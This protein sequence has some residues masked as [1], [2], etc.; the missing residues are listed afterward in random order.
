MKKRHYYYFL[1]PGT[2]FLLLFVVIPLLD[3]MF[4]TILFKN[5]ISFSGYAALFKDK[6]FLAIFFRSVKLSVISTVVCIIMG[7]PTSYFIAKITKNKAVYIALAIFP[8][9][10]SPVV[11]SFSWMVILGHNGFLNTLLLRCHLIKEPVQMLY[12]EF[13]IVV[14]LV[15]LFL[16]FMI[17]SVVGVMENINDD[18]ILAAENLGAPHFL[19]FLKVV[20]PLSVPGII[21]GSVL[22]LT[23]SL[24]AYTTP[25]L[26]GGSN[27]TVLS[28]MIYDD[29]MTLSDW[30]SAFIIAVVMIITTIIIMEI[31]SILGKSLS[32]AK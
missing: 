17:L 3:M 28:T 2:V 13:S 19:A 11:R 14:G 8:M 16:P 4:S 9:L 29:A 31:I 27:T 20:L 26:L 6:A 5:H 10:V 15:Q 22:V 21:T 24:T 30:N 7:F 25:K 18:L 23:G 32:S 12:T 1:I